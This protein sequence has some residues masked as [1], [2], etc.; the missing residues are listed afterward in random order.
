M[1]VFYYTSKT[2]FFGG[3]SPKCRRI[4]MKL[5]EICYTVYTF[6]FSPG[7]T[8][9][10]SFL[11][12]KRGFCCR[13]VSVCLSV[14]LS[15]TFVY[16][17][18]TVEDIVKLLRPSGSRIFLVFSPQALAPSSKGTTWAGALNTPGWGKV[19]DFRLKLSFNWEVVWDRRMVAVER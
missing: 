2:G 17:I 7:Q 4:W 13:P 3:Q 6:T 15:V 16:C 12:R 9:R 5:A 14:R 1:A 8:I 10:T 19:W 11:P 18:Q